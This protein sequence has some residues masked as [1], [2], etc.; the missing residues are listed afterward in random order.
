MTSVKRLAVMP[1][2]MIAAFGVD[3]PQRAIGE[4]D[5]LVF[6]DQAHIVRREVGEDLDLRLECVGDLLVAP[7]AR[8]MFA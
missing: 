5:R 1:S 6:V 7:S 3:Q 4:L 8:A 2:S